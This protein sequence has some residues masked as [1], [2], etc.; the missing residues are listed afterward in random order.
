LLVAL[1]EISPSAA[2]YLAGTS[3]TSMITVIYSSK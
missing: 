1:G 2:T 3:P